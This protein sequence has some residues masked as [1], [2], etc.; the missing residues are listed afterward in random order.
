MVMTNNLVKG[1]VLTILGA[2]VLVAAAMIVLFNSGPVVDVRLF[3]F[4]FEKVSLGTVM[5][6]SGLVGAFVLFTTKYMVIGIWSLWKGRREK[7]R[8][9]NKA[10][11]LSEREEKNKS[12]GSSG[13]RSGSASE[14]SS[15]STGG[16]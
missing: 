6:V 2:V 10:R 4:A 11:K 13:N 16:Q 15:G 5:V 14:S 1:Y 3:N 8:V 12:T 9:E 7:Q